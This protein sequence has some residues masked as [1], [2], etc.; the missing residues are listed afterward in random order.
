MGAQYLDYERSIAS[1][2]IDDC[3]ELTEIVSFQGRAMPSRRFARHRSVEKRTNA[4]LLRKI[5][6]EGHAKCTATAA[7]ARPNRLDELTP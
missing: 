7:L 1:S 3:L 6:L 4:W 5:L 2:N